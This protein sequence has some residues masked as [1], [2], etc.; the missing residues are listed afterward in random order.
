MLCRYRDYQ[1]SQGYWWHCQ[2]DGARQA[3]GYY[4]HNDIF[5]FI[6]IPIG[7]DIPLPLQFLDVPHPRK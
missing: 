7:K 4:L 3:G 5:A 6:L 2:V 1:D